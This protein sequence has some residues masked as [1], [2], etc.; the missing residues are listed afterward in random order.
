[1]RP[2]SPRDLEGTATVVLKRAA[3]AWYWLRKNFSLASVLTIAGIVGGAGGYIIHLQ[4]RVVIVERDVRTIK[5][6][7]PSSAAIATLTSQVQE[8]GE[9]IARLEKNWDDAAQSAGSAPYPTHR[10]KKP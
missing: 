3:P 6:I 9:R 2:A 5:E 4:T 8:Q 1:M 7:V 10:G